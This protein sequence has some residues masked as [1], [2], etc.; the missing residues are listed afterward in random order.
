MAGDFNGDG[1][2]DIGVLYNYGTNPD[3]T[4]HTALLVFASTGTGFADPVVFWDSVTS[5]TGTWDWNASTVVAGDFNGDGKT[6]IGVLYKYFAGG[7]DKSTHVGLWTFTSTGT[8]FANPV[9]AWDA[10]T[11]VGNWPSA[12]LPSLIPPD[13]DKGATANGTA[14]R[15]AQELAPPQVV[16]GDFNRDGKADLATVYGGGHGSSNVF[17]FTASATGFNPPDVVGGTNV[18]WAR[19]SAL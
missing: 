5:G 3:G 18:E 2:T 12:V 15:L 4:Y 14:V 1:K 17:A 10:G 13:S 8:G 6:D 7:T 11:G 9:K 16:V 19:A